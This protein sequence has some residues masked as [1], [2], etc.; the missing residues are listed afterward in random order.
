[1]VLCVVEFL[2]L[3][4][5]SGRLGENVWKICCPCMCMCACAYSY[6]LHKYDSMDAA[7]EPKGPRRLLL[8]W[9]LSVCWPQ[10]GCESSTVVEL[11]LE[12]PDKAFAVGIMW[13]TI[14]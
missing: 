7:S 9:L 14:I 8:L 2:C 12:A 3:M 5:G 10:K 11:R 13:S 6:V 1:M 4:S